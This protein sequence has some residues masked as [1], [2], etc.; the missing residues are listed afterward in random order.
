M[1]KYKIENTIFNLNKNQ[2]INAKI[3]INLCTLFFSL[4]QIIFETK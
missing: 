3:I 2:Y 4:K 1:Q